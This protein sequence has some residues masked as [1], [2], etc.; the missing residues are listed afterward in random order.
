NNYYTQS[1]S[2]AETDISGSS[3]F[4]RAHV[5]YVNNATFTLLDK[6]DVQKVVRVTAY[7]GNKAVAYQD[8][9]FTTFKQCNLY[10]IYKSDSYGNTDY[11]KYTVQLIS[12]SSTT[13]Y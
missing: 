9:S 3:I 6:S 5:T 2:S 11:L 4:T 7:L 8:Y 10:H 13:A 1:V 12:G